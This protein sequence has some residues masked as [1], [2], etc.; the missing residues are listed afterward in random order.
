VAAED[1]KTLYWSLV[2]RSRSQ[3]VIIMVWAFRSSSIYIVSDSSPRDIGAWVSGRAQS[4]SCAW[5]GSGRN[6]HGGA[7]PADVRHAGAFADALD[8]RLG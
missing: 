4:A 3:N 7:C 6:D 2:D 1:G 5:A 8:R